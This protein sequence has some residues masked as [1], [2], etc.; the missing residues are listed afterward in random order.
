LS[1]IHEQQGSIPEVAKCE[2]YLNIICLF[3]IV[4]MHTQQCLRYDSSFWYCKL[5]WLH[6]TDNFLQTIISSCNTLAHAYIENFISHTR[7]KH[8]LHIS[9]K[10]YLL[11]MSQVIPVGTATNYKQLLQLLQPIISSCCIYLLS[12]TCCYSNQL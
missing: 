8:L 2:Q 5:H 10:S 1:L 7:Y 6:V 11:H 4:K 12:H 3:L 9:L